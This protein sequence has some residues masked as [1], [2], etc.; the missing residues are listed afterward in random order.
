MEDERISS[1]VGDDGLRGRESMRLN[2]FIDAA[3]AFAVTLLVIS[4]DAIPA[5]IDDLLLALRGVPAFGLSFLMIAMFWSAHARWSRRYRLYDGWCTVLGLAL[6]FL[7]L[8]YVYPLKMMFA[9][10]M[11]AIS[12]GFLSPEASN[13]GPGAL[14]DI[15]L[16]FVIYG[17]IF[18]TLSMCLVGLHLR[19]WYRRNEIAQAADQHEL[20]GGDLFAYGWFVIVG[21]ISVFTALLIPGKLPQAWAWLVGVPGMLYALLSFSGVADGLGRRWA[22]RHWQA[23]GGV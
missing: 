15:L 8:V 11:A 13:L 9:S 10:F 7:V 3:F 1:G 14:P 16:M 19:V 18:A 5:T 4:I 20:A 17:V 23:K 6:V 22:R 12:G 2:A 21:L